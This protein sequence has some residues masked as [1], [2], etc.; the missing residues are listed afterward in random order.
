MCRAV[1]Y[2]E[3]LGSSPPPPL[4][5]LI[6][7]GSAASGRAEPGLGTK[8]G[9]AGCGCNHA[10]PPHSPICPLAEGL[11]MQRPPNAA[12]RRS[13]AIPVRRHCVRRGTTFCGRGDGSGDRLLPWPLRP[14]LF[15][16]PAEATTHR[17]SCN[18]RS[19]PLNFSQL[20]DYTL[21]GGVHHGHTTTSAFLII[22]ESHVARH[23]TWRAATSHAAAW[24]VI[25]LAPVFGYRHRRTAFCRQK[26]SLIGAMPA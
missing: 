19:R 22:G 7:R 1:L 25:G 21:D 17:G 2:L 12:E 4:C 3:G 13:P 10:T 16:R 8:Q 9:M 15:Q 24:N 23:Y 6:P 5:Q 20:H 11:P 26:P 18:R 14:D